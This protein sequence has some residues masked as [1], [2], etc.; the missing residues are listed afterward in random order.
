MTVTV[1][2]GIPAGIGCR[3]SLA[4]QDA[5]PL[6]QPRHQRLQVTD[7]HL[8]S[9]PAGDLSLQFADVQLWGLPARALALQAARGAAI[10]SLMPRSWLLFSGPGRREGLVLRP[11]CK[12]CGTLRPT[13]QALPSSRRV[14]TRGRLHMAGALRRCCRELAQARRR[15]SRSLWRHGCAGPKARGRHCLGLHLSRWV[16]H[17]RTSRSLVGCR[18]DEYRWRRHGRV[19]RP[20]VGPGSWRRHSRAEKPLTS[21]WRQRTP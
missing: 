8:G 12:S 7:L 18:I 15:H 1:L 16:L 21:G 14:V 3:P 5:D 6:P 17:Q 19:D 4:L 20:V 2:M 10:G 13:D 9:L 11:V